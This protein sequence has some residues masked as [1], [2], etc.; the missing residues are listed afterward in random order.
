MKDIPSYLPYLGLIGFVAFLIVIVVASHFLAPFMP[1]G[2]RSRGRH[3]GTPEPGAI[4]KM[5]GALRHVHHRGAPVSISVRDMG[6]GEMYSLHAAQ[7]MCE[8]LE[9]PLWFECR[10]MEGT[11]GEDVQVFLKCGELE[12]NGQGH[13]ALHALCSDRMS[14]AGILSIARLSI[15][16]GMI[17]FE[18][19]FDASEQPSKVIRAIES[20]LDGLQLLCETLPDTQEEA[21]LK[22]F[23][24][25]TD[26]DVHRSLMGLGVIQQHLRDPARARALV[27][28]ATPEVLGMWCAR[29]LLGVVQGVGVEASRRRQAMVSWAAQAS[30]PER[31][32]TTEE[33]RRAFAFFTQGQPALTPATLEARPVLALPVLMHQFASA[34]AQVAAMSTRVTRLMQPQ[35]ALFWLDHLSARGHAVTY[36]HIKD[37]SLGALTS[38]TAQGL[39]RHWM[40]FAAQ[41]HPS[42][43]SR[44]WHDQVAALL[45]GLS[46]DDFVRATQW[47][48]QHGN[49]HTLEM[50]QRSLSS[51]D[52]RSDKRRAFEEAIAFMLNQ[53]RNSGSLSLVADSQA[54]GLSV[55]PQANEGG[56]S[57]AFEQPA[58]ADQAARANASN[59]KP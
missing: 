54:G 17:S 27:E 40:A 22:I 12:I 51:S 41:G 25:N 50:L 5:R 57:F 52:R 20:T 30:T 37:I 21:V 16:R 31:G 46:E 1:R 10:L 29:G 43:A 35:D 45:S 2:R 28:R 47:L 3:E 53:R 26:A 59:H 23:A 48:A 24:S 38:P 6:G 11:Q 49:A 58:Q 7:V 44:A 36:D 8:H 15:N 34:P 55:S 13:E 33:S 14:V 19:A 42:F 32:L 56:V 39:L 4:E 9:V 18:V